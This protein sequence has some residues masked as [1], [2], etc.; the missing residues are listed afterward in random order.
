MKERLTQKWIGHNLVDVCTLC[1]TNTER[2]VNVPYPVIAK[3][4]GISYFS[5][6]FLL[7]IYSVP[8]QWRQNTSL[9]VFHKQ[10]SICAIKKKKKTKKK[11]ACGCL[12]QIH[13]HIHTSSRKVN[14]AFICN[15]CFTVFP[16]WKHNTV[17]YIIYISN[18]KYGWK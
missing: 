7:I 2:N 11:H 9:W 12:T 10:T 5:I 14:N 3:C 15:K 16:L 18:N 8:V 1:Y 17:Q 13:T 4:H 6:Y